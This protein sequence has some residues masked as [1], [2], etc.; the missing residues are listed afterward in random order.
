MVSGMT[1]YYRLVV[2][3]E[4]GDVEDVDGEVVADDKFEATKEARKTVQD[5]KQIVFDK[6]E[7]SK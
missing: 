4:N 3:R 5:A 7:K 1:W 6:L 2:T